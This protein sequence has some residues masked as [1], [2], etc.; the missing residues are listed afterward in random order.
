MRDAKLAVASAD[1][2]SAGPIRCNR[3]NCGS[4]MIDSFPDIATCKR[5][6]TCPTG[7]IRPRE[8]GSTSTID[9]PHHAK[10]GLK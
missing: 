3:V 6:N 2:P 10:A 4:D 7:G 1:N 8:L 9:V 5:T